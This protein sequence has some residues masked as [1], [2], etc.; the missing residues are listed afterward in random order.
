MMSAADRFAMGEARGARRHQ[1]FAVPARTVRRV[2]LAIGAAVAASACS[3]DPSPT[4]PPQPT[5]A[6]VSLSTPVLSLVRGGDAVVTATVTMRATE[7]KHATAPAA[8]WSSADTAVAR[9]V[10]GRVHAWGDGS[11]TVTASAGGKSARLPVTVTLPPRGDFQIT[12]RF[13]SDVPETVRAAARR[14]ADRLERVIVGDAPAVTMILPNSCGGGTEETI[15]DVAVYVEMGTT[16]SDALASGGPCKFVADRAAPAGGRIVVAAT[17]ADLP[18]AV[19]DNVMAHELAHVLG[20]G[21]SPRWSTA[22]TDTTTPGAAQFSGAGA[23]AAHQALGFSGSSVPVTDDLAHWR[24]AAY[25]HEL[26]SPLGVRLS[27]LTVGAFADLGYTVNADA[28]EPWDPTGRLI[29]P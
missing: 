14:V 8:T 18:T 19:V 12:W 1:Q 23:V 17:T 5:V 4:E 21:T 16:S 20:I 13:A 7:G 22:L 11:T 3:G 28:T 25:A 26:M 9:V 27:R 6:S 29:L 15:D 24:G 10:D 2:Q